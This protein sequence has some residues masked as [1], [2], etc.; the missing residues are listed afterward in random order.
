ML[1]RLEFCSNSLLR[2]IKIRYR[3]INS[4]ILL[5]LLPL[6]ISGYISYGES[7]KAIQKKTRIFSTEIVKQVSKNVQLQMAQIE[8]DS[9]TLVLSDRVQ[10]ALARY[11][12]NDPVEKGL[13]RA[14]TTKILLDT[15]GSFAHID[16]KYFLD[17]DN[18]IMD[19]QVFSQLGRGVVRIVDQAPHLKGRPYWSTLE[20]SSGQ[21]SIVMLRKIY[22]KA[23]NRMAGSLFLGIKQAHF[24][25]IFDDVDLGT[26]SDIYVLDAKDGS[27]IIQTREKSAMAGDNT[28]NRI[29]AEEIGHNMLRGQQIGFVTYESQGLRREPGKP[30]S[31]FVAAY[32]QIP[33]T[34]WFVVSAIPYNNLL[35]EAQSVRNKI[36]LIGFICFV[37]AIILSYIISRSIS[38]PLKKL[39]GIM[40]ET[41][42]GNYKIRMAHEGRDELTVLSQKFNEMASKIDHEYELLE[43]HVAERT[44]DLEEANRKLAALSMTDGL[45][46]IPN[47]RRFDEVLAAE[48]PRATRAGLPLALIMLDVDFF[49][50]YNDHYGHQEGDACLSIVAR[51]LESHARRASDLVARY[52]GEEF[53]MLAA[54]TDANSAMNLAESIRQSLEALALPHAQSPLGCV[55]SSIGVVVLVPGKNLA[56]EMFIRMADNAM[57]HAKAQGR[58]QV[59]LSE[60]KVG[61]QSEAKLSTVLDSYPGCSQS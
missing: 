51:L 49:K 30:G 27:V 19:S 54:V 55:T 2:K 43:E 16:Q 56:P 59:V 32:T 48:L 5:S 7:S 52:G 38:T 12:G 24:S 58:N 44:R 31:K 8:A 28:A 60:E 34:T 1:R 23:N 21:K 22:F 11:A 61:D 6:L 17:T 14:E 47:R 25:G 50:N 53:V 39:V 46:G 40:K 35:A 4:F 29:L 18:Q 9:E 20:V 15:Y 36:I 33:R 10:S 3:L 42:T 13:A 57:Y 45:T 41:E 26:D 37:C